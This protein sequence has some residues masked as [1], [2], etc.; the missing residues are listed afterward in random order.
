[1][2]NIRFEYFNPK[3]I[4]LLE[5]RGA[6]DRLIISSCKELIRKKNLGEECNDDECM[7]DLE[8]LDED[9]VSDKKI[10]GEV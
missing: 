3:Y 10:C 5:L 4:Y 7:G 2:D 1:M 6:V 9:E 8:C